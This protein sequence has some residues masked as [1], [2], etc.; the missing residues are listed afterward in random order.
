VLDAAECPG[1]C[2][3]IVEASRQCNLDQSFAVFGKQVFGVN[4]PK[5][6]F[7]VRKQLE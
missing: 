7:D 5:L 2:G 6:S 4:N 3:L 1:E